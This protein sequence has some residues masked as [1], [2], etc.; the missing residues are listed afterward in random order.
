M[1]YLQADQYT[2][3][4]SHIMRRDR[5]EKSLFVEIMTPKLLKFEDRNVQIQQAQHTPARINPKKC[6][7]GHFQMSFKLSNV[8]TRMLNAAGEK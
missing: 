7:S 5:R 2:H 3:H 4:R 6:I 8:I 1:R